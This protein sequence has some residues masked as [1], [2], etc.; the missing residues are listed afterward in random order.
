MGIVGKDKEFTVYDEN[1]IGR[2]LK[3]IEGEERTPLAQ[4]EQMEEDPAPESAPDEPSDP[5]PA[6]PQ[7]E[8]R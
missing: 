5:T 6:T 8:G 2:Y 3:M 1:E 4:T 7:T